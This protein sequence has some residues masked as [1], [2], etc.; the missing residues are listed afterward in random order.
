MPFRLKNT[1]AT[2]Q[3]LVNKI[4]KEQICKTMKVYVNDML[5][6]APSWANHIKN[7]AEAFKLLREYHM[8]LNPNKCTFGVSSS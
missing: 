4:F 8:K 7:L 1:G 6:K 5:V 2:Y 3:K